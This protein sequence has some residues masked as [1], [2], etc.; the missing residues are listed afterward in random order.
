[1]EEKTRA[2]SQPTLPEMVVD[3]VNTAKKEKKFNGFEPPNLGKASRLPV[4]N[5]S[6]SDRPKT[7][8]EID[9][10]IAPINAL[11]SL[12]G[13]AGKPIYQM[14][15]WWAR[16][17][18]S[19]FRSLLIAAATV[20][21]EDP[22]EAAKLVWEHYYSN[23]Q[24]SGNFK[25]LQVLDCF[26][27]GGTTM[28]EGARLGFQ[29]TGVD[30]N[31][32]AWFVVKNE[33][34]C[35]DPQQVQAF[36]C[37]IENMVK[38]LIQ[39][40]YTTTCPRGH[41][42]HWV[43]AD[44]GKYVN[45]DPLDLLPEQRRHYRWKGPE[46]IY[47]FWA[48]HGP[49]KAEGCGHRTPIFKN[50]VLSEKRLSVLYIPL[51]CTNCGH[52]FHAELG[53][54]RLAPEAERIV[55]DT[56]V[57]FTELSQTFALMLKDY[58]KGSPSK[59]EER[60]AELLGMVNSEIG[61]NCPKCSTFAGK[62]VKSVLDR[63]ISHAQRGRISEMRKNDFGIESKQVYMYLLI[64]SEWLHG[65]PGIYE[66]EEL[67][68]YAGANAKSTI[69]WYKE[70]LQNIDLIEV[71]GRIKLSDED[72]AA[73]EDEESTPSES[74]EITEAN[75]DVSDR[76]KYGLPFE[77]VL[78]NGIRLPTRR[79]TVPRK[80]AF[81][82][83]ACGRSQDILEAVKLSNHTAP[84]AIY[85]LQCY[86][87]ECDAEGYNYGG[88]Y[89]KAPDVYDVDRFE[90]SER[91]WFERSQS[92]L[93]DWW[94]REGL[95]ESYMTHRLNGGIPNWGYSHWWKMFNSR[96][97][98][99]HTQLLRAITDGSNKPWPLD[100]REQA[101]GAFQQYLRNQN[102][103]AFWNQTADKIEPMF[104]NANY[105]PKQQVVENCVFAELGRGNWKSASDNVIEGLTWLR[106]PWELTISTDTTV[107]KSSKVEPDDPVI[108]GQA[109][110]CQ[111]STDL[112][113]LN[114]RSFDLIITDPPFGNNLFYAVM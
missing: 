88:R 91:E 105:H 40:F 74:E 59:R 44:T 62:K 34:A 112:S 29:M 18:S 15:K 25:K 36:F 83:D 26:M 86:C 41:Q 87:P 19:V 30:L 27:G 70:R 23:F 42:G 54:T 67:G 68:G 48:K 90:R 75:Y 107:I 93:K 12:E 3:I 95:F 100:V 92:D 43:E 94:P 32:V 45:I 79:G 98:L 65:S 8:L 9:F 89:F 76:K 58:S 7:C 113:I 37:E 60:T 6:D 21:P 111:S 13:N 11:S 104:S 73:P 56:E 4:P 31:P 35:S 51:I 20:A 69:A 46:V 72:R 109:I 47:T 85:A 102:M 108:S 61:L 52:A 17:R 80:S 110:Y 78:N 71:R 53:E 24:K 101:L 99:V 1:M 28:V 63:H 50:P 16:R 106:E 82:C 64:N 66:G 10:P 39:P 103:F 49:C 77:V 81:K 55:L 84:V 97:L 38:P 14:S 2:Q 96:Q 57:P 5:F 114:G 22:T 33:L